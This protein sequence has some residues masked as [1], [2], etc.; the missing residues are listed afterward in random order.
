MAN[1]RYNRFDKLR[2][3]IDKRTP[4]NKKVKNDTSDE[5][6]FFAEVFPAVIVICIIVCGGLFYFL[7]NN[8]KEVLVTPDSGFFINSDTLILGSKKT[9]NYSNIL[10]FVNVKENDIIYKNAL[11]HYV[12]NSKEESV[13]VEY[14]LFIDKGLSFINYNEN[15]NLINHEF[16]RSTGYSGLLISYGRV[17]DLYTR[18]QIDQEKYLLLSYEDDVMIN[19]YDMKVKTYTDEYV[20][21]VNSFVYFE[22][23]MISYYERT[24]SGFKYNVIKDVDFES[25]ISFS[26]ESALEYFEYDYEKFLKG[27]DTIYI[28]DFVIDDEIDPDVPFEEIIPP[29]DGEGGNGEIV[30][31]EFVWQKPSVT[32][33]DITPSVY[34]LTGNIKIVDNAHVIVKE[35]TFTFYRNNKTFLRRTY[36]SSGEMKVTGLIPSTT[37]TMVGTYTYLAQDMETRIAVTFYSKEI[38]TGSLDSLEPINLSFINGQIYPKKVEVNDV[39][40]DSDLQSEAISGVSKISL[41]IGDKKFFLSNNQVVDIINGRET[42]I[43]SPESLSSSSKID[44]EFKLLD[45]EG[46]ELKSTNSSGTTRTSKRHPNVSLR[47][48]NSEIDSVT[49]GL[50]VKNEDDIEFNNYMYIVKKSDG[51]IVKQENVTSDEIV[52]TNLDPD[53]LFNIVLYADY[54]IDDGNGLSNHQLASMD[55]TSKPITTLGY[56]NLPMEIETT[57]FDSVNVLC[58]INS[59]KTNVILVKLLQRLKFDVYDES[60]ST[61]VDSVIVDGEDIQSLKDGNKINVLFDYLDSFT[62]YKVVVTTIIQQGSTVYEIGTT[63]GLEEFMTNKL[64]AKVNITN[65]FTTET[66]IDFDISIEDIDHA[67]ESDFVRLELRDKDQ[68][69]VNTKRISINGE[70]ERITYNNLNTN[71]FYNIFVYADGY[72]ET[73][74]S[75]NYKSKYLMFS[76]SIYTESGI[77]GKIELISSL[78]E[79]TGS[80]IADVKSEVKWLQMYN[81]KNIP[82]TV[83]SSGDLH[84]YSKDGAAGY[85][86]DLSKYHGE[87][88]TVTFKIK[89]IVPLNEAYKIYFTQYVSGSTNTSYSKELTGITQD[90]FKEY[91]F[92]FKVGS[93]SSLKDISTFDTDAAIFTPTYQNSIGQNNLDG[94]GF[95]LSNGTGIMSEYVVRDFEIHTQYDIEE[96]NPPEEIKLEQGSYSKLNVFDSTKIESDFLIT[97][98]MIFLEGKKRYLFDYED[99]IDNVYDIRFYLFDKNGKYL[100]AYSWVNREYSFYVPNDTYVRVQFRYMNEGGYIRPDNIKNLKLYSYVRNEKTGNSEYQ[101]E[102]VTKAKINLTDKRDE[103]TNDDYYIKIYE[104][105]KEYKSYNYVELKDTL[106]LSDVIKNIELEEEKEYTVELGILIR[107]RYYGLST[108]EISTEDEVLGISTLG[109]W[110]KIQPYGHYI[111]LN[112]L[113]FQNFTNRRIGVGYRYF[114]GVIDFQGYTMKQ[115]T[116]KTDGSPNT[117]YYRMYRIENDAVLKNLVLDIQLNNQALNGNVYG[118][119]QYNYG[120]IE[121]VVLK[122]TDTKET[123]M[124]QTLQGLLTYQNTL[125]GRIR[126][127]V[128]KLENDLHYYSTS[129]V[130]VRE[131]YGLI[132]NGYVYGGDVVVDFPLVSGDNR[133]LGIL[134]RYSGPRAVINHVFMDV[135]YKFPNN[136]TYDKGGIMAYSNAGIIQNSYVIGDTNIELPDIGPIVQSVSGTSRMDNVYYLS[137]YIYTSKFQDKAS[138]SSLHDVDFQQ[139]VLGDNFNTEEMVSLGYFPQLI[140]SS[141]KMPSQEFLELP[142]VSESDYADIVHMEVT[143]NNVDSAKVKVIV[144]NPY[145]EDVTEIVIANLTTKIDSQEFKDGKSTVMITVSNPTT[146]ESKYMVSSITTTSSNGYKTTRK[147]KTHELFLKVEMFK[148]VYTVEEYMQIKTMTNQNFKIMNDLDFSGYSNYYVGTFTGVLDGGGHTFK[149][150]RI[151][152]TSFSGLMTYMYGTVK[153]LN[154]ENFYKSSKTTYHGLFG[155]TNSDSRVTN[156]HMKN[157]IIEIGETMNS[158]SMR[159]GA[160]VGQASSSSITF[161]SATNVKI[162]TVSEASSLM[163][164][165]LVGRSSGSA[166]T[167]SYVQDLDIDIV[168]AIST[169]GVGGIV[170][171]ENSSSVGLIDTS[172]AIGR[173]DTNSANVGGIVGNGTGYITDSYSAVDIVSDMSFVGG[174]NGNSRAAKDSVETSIYLGNLYSASVDQYIH[175]ISANYESSATN[176][177]MSTNLI[178]GE[179]NNKTYGENLLTYND[180]L[181]SE[182]YDMIFDAEAFDLSKSSE[183]ILPK[184]FSQDGETLL[185]NQKD[186]Y[187]YVNMFNTVLHLEEYAEYA[188]VLLNIDNPNNYVI[189]SINV[190]NA[191]VTIEKNVTEN[192]LTQIQLQLRPDKYLDSYRISELTYRDENNELITL[193]RNIRLD[194]KFYKKLRSYDDWQNVSTS[195]AENYILAEDIDFTGK[196]NIKTRVMFNRLESSDVDANGNPVSHTIKGIDLSYT[197][198]THYNVLIQKVATSLKNVNFED[199]EIHDT[200]SSKNNYVGL[201]M[202]NYA[203]MSNCTFKD[204][205]INAPKENYVAPIAINYAYILNNIKL[206]RVVV[207]GN[208]YVAGFVAYAVNTTNDKYE[209]IHGINLDVQGTGESV[210]GLFGRYAN[211]INKKDDPIYLNMSVKDSKIHGTAYYVG[212]ISGVGD[213]SYCYVDNVNVTGNYDIGGIV[214]HFK[215]AYQYGNLVENSHI[216]GTGKNIGGVYGYQY[217]IYDMHV[218]N[219]TIEGLNANTNSVGGITG[220]RTGS[221][222]FYRCGVLDSNIINKGERTGGLIGTAANTTYVRYSYITDSNVISYDSAG[223]AIGYMTETSYLENNR[224]S[225]T[226]VVAENYYAG[227]LV[228]YYNND[229]AYGS[230]TEGIVRDDVLENVNVQAN[231]YAGG[232]FGAINAD[233]YYAER[234]RKLYFSGTVKSLSGSNAGLASGD[235]HN[236][237]VM[238]QPRIYAYNKSL[239]NGVEVKE[240]AG[241]KEVS[242]INLLED[243]VYLPG[244]VASN[245]STSYNENDVKAVYSDFIEIKNGKSYVF[246]VDYITR[247]NA[248]NVYLYDSEQIFKSAITSSTVDSYISSYH[249]TANYDNIIFTAYKDC[250]LRIAIT[251]KD[252]VKEITLKEIYR[253]SVVDSDRLLDAG[254]LRESLTWVDQTSTTTQANASLLNLN[255]SYWDYTELHLAKRPVEVVDKTASKYEASGYLAAISSDGAMFQSNDKDEH[256]LKVNNYKFPNN[257]SFTVNAKF[258]NYSS[259]SYAPIITA[260]KSNGAV[261]FG[262]FSHALQIGVLVGNKWYSTGY[263]IPYISDVDITVTYNNKSISLYIDGEFIKTI[264]TVDIGDLSSYNTYIGYSQ[265]YNNSNIAYN[266]IGH[267]MNVSV[268]DRVLDANEIRSNYNS[269]GITNTNNLHLNYDFTK[270][271]V[272]HDANYMPLKENL[273]AIYPIKYQRIVPMPK[274]T[275]SY[276]EMP[277]LLN[278]SLNSPLLNQYFDVYSSGIDTINVEFKDISRDLELKYRIGENEYKVNVDRKVYTLHYDYVSDIE[279]ELSNSFESKVLRYKASDLVKKIKTINK[280]YY[281]I[282]NEGVLYRNNGKVIDDAVHIYNNL[283]LLKNGK[284]YNLSTSNVQSMS[285]SVGILRNINS[286]RSTILNNKVINTYYNYTV[287]DNEELEGQLFIKDSHAYMFNSNEALNDNVVYNLY[288]TDEYQIVLLRDG[289][290]SSYKAGIKLPSSFVNKNIKEITFDDGSKDTIIMIRYDSGNVLAFNYI[291]GE[292]VFISGEEMSASLFEYLSSSLS[293][294]T[295]SLSNSSEEYKESK[296]FINN[297]NNSNESILKVLDSLSSNDNSTSNILNTEYISVYNEKTNNFDVYNV[298]ELVTS[299]NDKIDN[300]TQ[301]EFDPEDMDEVV[302]NIIDVSKNNNNNNNKID[303]KPLNSKVKSNFVL[304]DYFFNNNKNSFVEDKKTLIYGIIIGF[305]IIN[306]FILSYVYNKKENSYEGE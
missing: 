62:K 176:Y 208:T 102:L 301:V 82:K 64:P 161:C 212:G 263:Y 167:N 229:G 280:D 214:G 150:I 74:S 117:Y 243:I 170:G 31:P 15:I 290:L 124:P 139:K 37:F 135:T 76:K 107:D 257:K 56:I 239:V 86:Y 253:P 52:L 6:T 83:D 91:S 138:Y 79:P 294:S 270:E 273:N 50:N 129:A 25:L 54:D 259:R 278:Y 49:I 137:D 225:N 84:I 155:L 201:I 193:D 216:S 69:I 235:K 300:N 118:F 81:D 213:C 163:V 113:D 200:S 24:N 96:Y 111:L 152:T 115:A 70:P 251:D 199:I 156:V 142:S 154:V 215:G 168:N 126:N 240:N 148:R 95:Y 158:D 275:D 296:K 125:K 141:N 209:N 297:V 244:Y 224:I 18:T 59:R 192:G 87:I 220:Y 164:G 242:S 65:P 186:N 268:F 205:V 271:S 128:V 7:F 181:K 147:Y 28:K 276:T 160:L 14:P 134:T 264:S 109:D 162:S 194:A 223:G 289:S 127:F 51:S 61:I 34:T 35:P 291:T 258:N 269:S 169:L 233:I 114:H 298:N 63:Q 284:V 46:N 130:L 262:V 47:I 306:L 100:K 99:T 285:S 190:E 172:Y 288:N 57:S 55:F 78:R 132:E 131:N 120:T 71:E 68:K 48:K 67:I 267:I 44:Y 293:N 75:A 92:S 250:Y 112:D 187:L 110:D 123:Q 247:P 198:N 32:I 236:I 159:I 171:Q 33:S 248:Y 157:A 121:N 105:G 210:A 246:N 108:F 183:G 17:F 305:V 218:K 143:Q 97:S 89:A 80:N 232:L 119:V 175:R 106:N 265:H 231:H 292:E 204:I 1:S 30:K 39:K 41:N 191:F 2:E 13:N 151:T 53:Q 26:Y 19:L 256:Y 179:L 177:A 282:D 94:A 254:K 40:V 22:E 20:I 188:D 103:I 149:N 23:N 302:D 227:G 197:T 279:I 249:T 16:E 185:P 295:Y 88:V 146:Y 153:N 219:S 36:Y 11:N 174:I 182:T 144:D 211:A 206:D 77:S 252:S 42:L 145:G 266:F 234:I 221:G 29:S 255:K 90:D 283:V 286:I 3:K 165:G 101:Y 245:G 166:I 104:N 184:L 238:D 85:V 274:Y 58:N 8:Y 178:N 27:I 98:N 261:G 21:P 4:L 196:K 12:D 272:S 66:M 202:Y 72:N 230:Y 10:E 140:F 303:V 304:Y 60:G 222:E 281:H 260:M 116:A 38:T 226:N 237:E 189:E 93:Y 287:V 45:R 9:N 228:G 299:K 207:S 73:A 5:N 217:H 122:I 180:Y 203:E 173:I 195:I 43:E 277:I 136:A 133:Q 241:V